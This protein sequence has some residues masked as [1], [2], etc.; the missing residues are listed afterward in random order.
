MEVFKEYL[1]KIEDLSKR[2]RIEDI[3]E[4]VLIRYPELEPRIA[5][6]QPMFTHHGTFIIGFSI[7]KKHLSVSPEKVF[8]D[9]FSEKIVQA[10]YEHSKMLIRIPWDM[11]VDFS[12]IE[13]MIEFIILDKAGC[14]AFWKK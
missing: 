9:R 5:W 13:K 12:L 3:L 7:S 1:A 10:G 2:A 14:S 11:A 4:R 6:N 8:I